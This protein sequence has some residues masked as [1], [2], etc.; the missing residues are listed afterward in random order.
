MKMELGTSFVDFSSSCSL[1][2]FISGSTSVASVSYLLLPDRHVELEGEGGL[3]TMIGA[4][5]FFRRLDDLLGEEG[6]TLG[7]ES[8]LGSNFSDSSAAR[9]NLLPPPP[10]PPGSLRDALLPPCRLIPPPLA[11]GDA[12]LV[13]KAAGN[14]LPGGWGVWTLGSDC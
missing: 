5:E 1:G 6:R 4:P 8:R 9:E 3:Q 10:P 13:T 14:T 2:S 12:S 11:A 7:L